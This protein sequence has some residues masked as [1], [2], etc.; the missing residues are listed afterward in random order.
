MNKRTVG[1]GVLA[2][3][4]SPWSLTIV[5]F[6]PGWRKKQPGVMQQCMVLGMRKALKI[7]DMPTGVGNHLG[8]VGG[9]NVVIRDPA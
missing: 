3:Y 9:R 8:K 1:D 2:D 4:L 7:K 6:V 5:S